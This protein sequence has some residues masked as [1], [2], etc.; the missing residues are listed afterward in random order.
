[1]ATCPLGSAVSENNWT[2]LKLCKICMF[3]VVKI[4]C[5]VYYNNCITLNFILQLV[6]GVEFHSSLLIL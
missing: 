3:A 4:D 5:N 2:A 1:M 6:I